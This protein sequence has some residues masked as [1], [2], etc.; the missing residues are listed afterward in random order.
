MQRVRLVLFLCAAHRG[1]APRPR[2]IRAGQRG[3]HR[4]ADDGYAPRL[5]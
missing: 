5:A 4:A 1:H 3:G 2:C